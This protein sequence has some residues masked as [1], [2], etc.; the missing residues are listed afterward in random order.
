[1]TYDGKKRN[2]LFLGLNVHRARKI[3]LS[4]KWMT[5][6][7]VN[8][9]VFNIEYICIYVYD[10][11]HTY[12]YIIYMYDVFILHPPCFCGIWAFRMS[13]LFII[14]KKKFPY[15]LCRFFLYHFQLFTS[16]KRR[17]SS[18]EV[19]YKLVLFKNFTKFTGKHLWRNLFLDK[20]PAWGPA[21]L[22]KK[23]LQHRCFL[24]LSQNF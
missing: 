13:W 1:M 21:T 9:C 11:H 14:S 2:L 12:V 15:S 16:S 20:V 8:W 10:I 4:I 18:S 17:S 22:L 23:K 5:P 19:F 7:L 24:W 3:T 6:K